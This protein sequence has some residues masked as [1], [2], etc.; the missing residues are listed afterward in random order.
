MADNQ[1]GRNIQH[2]R[3]IR[4][5][6]LTEM[7][8]SISRAKTTTKGYENGSREPDLGTLRLMASHFNKTVD[9]LLFSDLTQVEKMSIDW[10]SPR[11][12]TELLK[13]IVPLFTSEEAM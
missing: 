2:L 12:M 9:E 6:T 5:E 3:E 10:N 1:F 13:A 4:S 11:Y 8:N 7:G